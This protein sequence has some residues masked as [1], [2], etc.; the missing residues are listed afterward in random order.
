MS[1]GASALGP[2]G[3][4]RDIEKNRC[5]NRMLALRSRRT[6]SFERQIGSP[7]PTP[8]NVVVRL[9]C[10]DQEETN[11]GREP[12]RDVRKRPLPRA[13]D[14]FEGRSQLGAYRDKWDGDM[15]R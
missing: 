8:Q 13:P 6:G 10:P 3:S 7:T 14:R 9:C 11:A 2:G 12:R 5:G 15:L 4:A 1:P